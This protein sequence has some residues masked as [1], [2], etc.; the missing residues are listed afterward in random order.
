MRRWQDVIRTGLDFYRGGDV[1]Y[2]YGSNGETGSDALVDKLWK[3]YPEH[4]KKFVL[5]NGH[6]KQELKDHVRGH[7][8]FDCSSFVS[9]CAGLTWHMTSGVLRQHFA[10][11]RDIKSG[12]WGSCVWKEGHVG[13]DFFGYVLEC[14]IEFEDLQ[15]NY[16]SARDFTH[17]GELDMVDYTGTSN[18]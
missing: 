15:M 18:W 9:R 2:L 10:V 6:T 16:L 8:C 17:S 1:R 14:R 7:I 12:T 3:E 5:D 4:F 11:T 13:I